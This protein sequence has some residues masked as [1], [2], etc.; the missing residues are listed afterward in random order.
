MFF[1]FSSNLFYCFCV[2]CFEKLREFSKLEYAKCLGRVHIYFVSNLT[3]VRFAAI[4]ATRL[5]D[6]IEIPR[7]ALRQNVYD[8]VI[9]LIDRTSST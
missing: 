5:G 6:V 2:W 7:I 3:T 1:L 4:A 8:N 9:D